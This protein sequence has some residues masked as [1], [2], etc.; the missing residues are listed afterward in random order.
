M[1]RDRST[2]I[3]LGAG[4]ALALTVLGPRE[5]FP[6]FTS[7][8]RD[9][10]TVLEGHWQSCPE[11]DG[12]FSERVYDHVVNGAGRFE[13]HLGP[14]NQ[15]AI[16]EGVQD[17]HRDHGSPENLLKPHIVPVENG[18]AMHRWAIP[19]LGLTFTATLAGGS[20]E[21]C[22]SWFITLAPTAGS[23]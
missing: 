23:D 21:D 15:F 11:A 13:V 4:I 1:R 18:R 20:F 22:Y 10:R 2:G 19:A 7:F 8:R 14:R 6:Q 3:R 17:E 9:P 12:G 5:A 16:F